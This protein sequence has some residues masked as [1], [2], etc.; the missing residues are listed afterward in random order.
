MWPNTTMFWVRHIAYCFSAF[1]QHLHSRV[2][3][4]LWFWWWLLYVVGTKYWYHTTYCTT[5]YHCLWIILW[6]SAL[7]PV[8]CT[9]CIVPYLVHCTTV[10]GTS[11]IPRE[12]IVP[13]AL[14]V[15][16]QLPCHEWQH[17][18]MN[19]IDAI[20]MIQCQPKHYS[21]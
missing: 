6:K 19:A 9:W 5:R 18:R 15:L 12:C 7:Y 1:Y 20:C 21:M 8:Y 16:N 3:C 4:T 2:Y 14:I 11:T 17:D 10:P 13:S